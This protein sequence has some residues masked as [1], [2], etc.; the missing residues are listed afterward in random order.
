MTNRN[1]VVTGLI[2]GAL[3]GTALGML[4]APKTGKETRQI[5][6][7]KTSAIKAKAGDYFTVIRNKIRKGDE[8][9]SLNGASHREEVSL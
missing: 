5:V 9:E 3:V 7:L 8:M 4:F 1:Q 2:A 6:G